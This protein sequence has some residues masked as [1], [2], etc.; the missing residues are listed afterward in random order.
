M[1]TLILF[2]GAGKEGSISTRALLYLALLFAMCLPLAALRIAPTGEVAEVTVGS[3]PANP[4][5]EI[6]DP[7][8]SISSFTSGISYHPTGDYALIWNNGNVFF[9][10]GI[11]GNVTAQI[12]TA[13]GSS[14]LGT[15]GIVFN[16]SQIASQALIWTPAKVYRRINGG[17]PDPVQEVMTAG[18]SISGVRGV[19]YNPN[20]GPYALIWTAS[21]LYFYNTGTLTADVI[22]DG[23]SA[24]GGTQGI[25]FNPQGADA[26]VWTVSKVYRHTSNNP[27]AVQEIMA[28]GSING[29]RGIVYDPQAAYAL[30]WNADNVYFYI[31][32]TTTQVVRDAGAAIAGTD[33][34]VLNPLFGANQALIWTPAKVYRHTSS[35]PTAVQEIM[36]GGSINGCARHRLPSRRGIRFDVEFRQ[37]LFPQRQHLDLHGPGDQRRD[38]RCHSW[39]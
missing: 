13:G 12:V 38:G 15:Q 37:P 39:N 36:A 35:N 4:A 34:I 31:G 30:I 20:N 14:I 3:L 29:V 16:P 7:A 33:G 1:K 9:H 18:G 24:I 21:N 23:M 10:A 8:G 2:L 22:T 17:L 32:T 27:T 6:D 26:L 28:G 25:V 19:V 5:A 11:M